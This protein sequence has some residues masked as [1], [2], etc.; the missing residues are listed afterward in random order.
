MARNED[1]A[2]MNEAPSRSITSLEQSSK[3]KLFKNIEEAEARLCQFQS[4]KPKIQ[5]VPDMLRDH[6]NLEKYYEPRAVALGPFHHDKARCQLAE[7]FKLALAAKFIQ[8]SGRPAK[9]LH[10]IVEDNI[11]TLKD[12][13]DE[14][15]TMSYT[16]EALT[17]LLFLDGCSTLQ[18]I[19]SFMNNELA[20]FKIKR[21]QVAFAE[22]DL[23]LL[24]NQLPY[25]VLKLLMSLSDKEMEL[26]T[27][28]DG[29]V[30]RNIMA[31]GKKWKW[32]KHKKT[33]Q[34]ADIVVNMEE[35]THLLELLRTK[36]LGPKESID[37]KKK[38]PKDRRQS[39][40]NI[41]EL[42][43]TGIH[44]KPSKTS[45]LRDISFTHLLGFAGFLYLSPISVDDSTRPK[46][47]NLIAYEMCPDFQNDFGV[48]SYIC[49]LDSLIDHA[50]D[51]KQLRSARVLHNLL[52]SDEEV[53]QL[54]N[55]I[56]T[57]LVPNSETYRSVKSKLEKHYKTKWKNW[58]AQFCH[59]HF[60][61]PWTIL[62]FLGVLA[63]LGLSSIQTWYTINS[64]PSACDA[65]C[66]YLKKRLKIE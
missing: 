21:D 40:R 16:N 52:G 14:E 42:K 50:D 3:E 48:T 39:F 45:T 37:P 30:G 58:M 43:A 62:A 47:L 38:K 33:S 18:F 27:A 56:G 8:D 9:D 13:Y 55:E 22:Q 34:P 35:P 24:E 23:F 32:H 2:S 11:K 65:V 44:L 28:I 26:K 19:Y 1:M 61:S 7:K 6:P 54:F 20:N 5:R 46:F 17:H 59:D 4:S 12:C 53:A 15:A 63:A 10:K 25:Q 36:M 60:S 29:F 66:E 51:V 49:F 41:Q 57:D 64:P 31:A